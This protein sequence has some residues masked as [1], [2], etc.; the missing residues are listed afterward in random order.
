MLHLQ[1]VPEQGSAAEAGPPASG[2]RPTAR[3]KALLP[4]GPFTVALVAAVLFALL[5]QRSLAAEH[6]AADV[7]FT[8]TRFLQA[9][10]NFRGDSIGADVADIRSFAVGDFADQ[11]G[12]FFNAG[13]MDAL[14][15][16]GTVS[17]GR[18]QSVFVESVNG[19]TASVFGVVNESVGSGTSASTQTE[20][21]RIHVDLIDTANGWKVSHVEILQ[22]PTQSPIGSLP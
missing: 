15:R 2:L 14:R 18:I 6:R 1:P 22:S 3:L 16:A 12:T 8:A 9:L 7:R 4:W 19:A 5:W 13:T 20:V 21:V 17:T 10:T 11:V